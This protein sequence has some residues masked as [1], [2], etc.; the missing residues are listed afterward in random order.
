MK[1]IS[2]M[3]WQK[4]GAL[5]IQSIET[6]A[7][8]VP[9]DKV[10]RGSKYQMQNRCTIITRIKTHQGVIGE[11]YTGDTDEEQGILLKIIHQELAPALIGM[12]VFNTEG[13][14]QAMKPATYDILRDRNMAMQ[15]ISCVDAAIWDTVGKALE[16][17]LY[18]LWGGYTNRLPIIAIG[19]YY[20]QT[21]DQLAAEIEAYLDYSVVGMK[22][23]IG[24]LT[25]E[26]DIERLKIARQVAG[27]SFVLMVDANQGYDLR[28]AI[29]FCRLAEESGIPLAWFEEPVRWYNDRLWLR[30]VRLTT[31]VPVTAGQSAYNLTAVRDLI[32]DGA[33][34]YCNFD[35]SWAGGPTMWRRA[36][37]IADAYGVKM[38]HHEEA[39]IAAHLLASIAHGSYVECF[40]RQRDPIFWEIQTESRPIQDGMY[41]LSDAPGFGISL[42]RS[43]VARYRVE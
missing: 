28:Q 43:Y 24:G 33:V 8:R 30:D 4:P 31:G 11:V 21:H 36:A 40:H 17:P 20:G 13:C 6:E 27:D 10:Y 42:D 9:L 23:K 39:Q 1:W 32:V 18:K 35:A 2:I 3:T 15:A 19:G 38:A 41:T 5:T 29:Q 16:M 22:F 25:P 37:A 26:E 14:W 7:I 12:D 34:D